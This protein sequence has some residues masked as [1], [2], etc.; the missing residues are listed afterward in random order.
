VKPGRRRIAGCST[1]SRIRRGSRCTPRLARDLQQSRERLA[2]TR[3]EERRRLRRDLHDDLAPSLAALALGVS[4]A[5]DL[6]AAD[7]TAATSLLRQLEVATRATVGEVRRLVYD[8]RPPA[9]DELGLLEAI[10]DRARQWSGHGLAITVEGPDDLPP[11]PAAV[12][13]AA[14]RIIQEAVMNVVRHAGARHCTVR[15]DAEKSTIVRAIRAAGQGEAIFSPAIA[16]RLIDFF[17]AAPAVPREVFP[18]LTERER[19]I[20]GLIAQGRS[21]TDIAQ[22][23]ALSAKT[24]AN[25]AS[26]IFNKLQ[27]ADRSQ[28]IVR[29]RDAGLGRD[30]Q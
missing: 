22:E 24:V 19:E 27:V 23:L 8:L 12:E 18:A 28:A 16:T 14:Y 10:R 29:A 30:R 21:N 5:A 11:L 20:L 1:R 17:A 9:L 13:V 2:L 25:Y 7:P 3:E 26:S 6:V 4:T 15:K